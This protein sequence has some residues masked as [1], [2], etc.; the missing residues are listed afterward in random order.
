MCVRFEVS[1]LLNLCVEKDV[2][3]LLAVEFVFEKVVS[4]CKRTVRYL[5]EGR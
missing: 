1:W 5:H 3:W 4:C 2:S